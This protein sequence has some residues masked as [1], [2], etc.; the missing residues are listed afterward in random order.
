MSEIKVISGIEHIRLRA[1][2]HIGST[3]D[4]GHLI[5]EIVDN[6]IDELLNGHANTIT[7]EFD[8]NG[9]VIVTDN[10]RG[11]PVQDVKLPDGTIK[12]SVVAATCEI[13]SGGKFDD[14]TYNISRGLNGIGLSAVNA[15]SDYLSFVIK[16]RQ[17][18]KKYYFYEFKNGEHVNTETKTFNKTLG[19]STRVEFHASAKYFSSLVVRPKP[20]LDWLQLL[21]AQNKNA[22]VT[23]NGEKLKNITMEQYV[24]MVYRIPSKSPIYHVTYSQTNGESIDAYFTYLAGNADKNLSDVNLGLVHGGKF[25]SSFQT[26]IYNCVRE[27]YGNE[28]TRSEALTGLRFYISLKIKDASF[29]S[30]DKKEL[31]KDVSYLS[32]HLKPGLLAKLK[33][34]Y[35]KNHFDELLSYRKLKA[36]SKLIKPRGKRVSSDNPLKD[37]IQ[38]PGKILYLLEG[39]SAEGTLK[40]VRDSNTEAILPVNGKI[41]NSIKLDIS[42]INKI[43]STKKSK[44]KYL[45]EAIG[46]DLNPDKKSNTYRY[47]QYKIICDADPD[48]LHISVLLSIIFWRFAPDLIKEGRV[49]IVL[50]PLYGATEKKTGKFYPVYDL[51]GLAKYPDSTYTI[52]RFKG[53]G[54]MNPDQLAEVLKS[55]IEYTP[56]LP[57][58]EKEDVQVKMLV[59]DSTL[60][61]K[62]CHE[63]TKIGL[64]HI[65]HSV[66]NPK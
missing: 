54:E 51:K 6:A 49:Q 38:I 32:N 50:P 22:N 33:V 16:D 42:D 26:M 15:L 10:G 41:M 29:G 55:P 66:L 11:F 45:F 13:F 28:V 56:T 62:I 9:K 31:S 35:I 14:S 21:C 60:K 8:N 36:A 30:Q 1:T 2:T 25:M 44:L 37:C 40:A 52:T 4:H 57:K 47:N 17:N 64:N 63:T 61:K 23:V 12:N 18:D 20:I 3:N 65:I 5:K 7:L 59:T 39:D 46:I 34:P 58:S 27:V 53:L 24:R 43:L 19:Y 48:G